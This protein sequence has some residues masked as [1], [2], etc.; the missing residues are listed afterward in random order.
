[1]KGEENK[2]QVAIINAFGYMFP[3][4]VKNLIH[5]PN[6]GYRT[7]IEGRIFKAM[8]VRA[9]VPDLLLLLP[10]KQFPFMGIELKTAKGRQSDTQKEYQQ[11]F[12]RAGAKYVIVRSVSE[13]INEVNNYMK[14]T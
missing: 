2:L 4:Y 7:P 6:G 11:I 13:F 10:N 9:G 12:E 3:K 1:M 14:N 5:V 8:G